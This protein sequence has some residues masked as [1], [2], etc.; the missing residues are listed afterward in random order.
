M[1]VKRVAF[2]LPKNIIGLT[3]EQAKIACLVEGYVLNLKGG[4]QFD[5]LNETYYVTVSNI[6][7]EGKILD[8]KYGK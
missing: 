8:A 1:K 6:D 5:F 7:S 4:N 3:I 2:N